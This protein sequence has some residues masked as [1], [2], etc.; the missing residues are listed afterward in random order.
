MNILGHP[1]ELIILDV[2]GVILD[3]LAGLRKNLEQAASYLGFALEPIAASL[4]QIAQGRMRIKGNAH[5]STRMIW[6]HV[7]EDEITEFAECFHAVERDSPYAPIEGSLEAIF[8]FLNH[9]PL[10]LATNNPRDV[11]EWRLASA[12]IHPEWFAA[13]VTKD[14][15]Y[16]KPHPHTFDPIFEAIPVPRE[17]TL[18]IGDLQVDWDMARGSG[19]RFL[20]VLTGGIP[21]EAFVHEG[22]PTTHILNRLGCILQ[23]IE[24]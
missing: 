2:D 15:I 4:E 1:V 24:P 23:Y 16:F 11:L 20:A 7:S 14:N 5:D 13:I 12:G 21:R 18:Y 9:I 6:P 17:H 8:F 10:A 19:V 22:V 3:I